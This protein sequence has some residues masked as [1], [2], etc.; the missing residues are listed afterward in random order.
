MAGGPPCVAVT[1]D[2]DEWSGEDSATLAEMLAEGACRVD[3]SNAERVAHEWLVIDP[4]QVFETR[5]GRR[6]GA[7]L[8]GKVEARVRELRRLD[9]FVGGGDLAAVVAR[10]LSATVGLLAEAAYKEAVGRR[11]LVAVGELAQLAGWAYSDAGEHETAAR[12]YLAGVRA[13]H[14]AGDFPLAGNLLSCLSYQHANTGKVREAVLMARSASRGAER[15]ATAR[16][17]ALLADRVAWAHVK[18]GESREAGRALGAADDAFDCARP[19]DE[20]PDWVYWVSRDELDV[21]AGR[22]FTELHRPLRAEPLLRAVLA[23]YDAAYVRETALY[24]TWLAD[25][26]LDAG[27]IEQAVRV[28]GEALELAARVNSARGRERVAAVRERL[29]PYLDVAAV[30]D[31]EER[32]RAALAR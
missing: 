13:A 25:T 29:R 14:A 12:Y 28:A 6:I 22:C 10:E 17:R 8:V 3:A 21:M 23:R 20:D 16:T 32:Y 31:F 27:E 18:A 9:D 15:A 26:Y 11:L 19:G 1:L 7:G 2:A 30:R 5:A 24:R 4:P